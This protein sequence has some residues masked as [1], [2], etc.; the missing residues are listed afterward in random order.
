MLSSE[1][2]RIPDIR[3]KAVWL[4]YAIGMLGT[5]AVGLPLLLIIGNSWLV[6]LVGLVGLF[7][8]GLVTGRMVSDR[9]LLVVNGALMA[10]LYNS[11]V[12]LLFFVGSFLEVLPEPLPGLPTGDSTFF[13]AWP[14]VQFAIGLLSAV[15]GSRIFGNRI[16][17]N[18]DAA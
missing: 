15:I 14:L 11:T 10:I 9:L 8:G 6:A 4:G 18:A 13:F 5:V 7:I 2:W 3:W 1:G 16:R 17:R 12:S